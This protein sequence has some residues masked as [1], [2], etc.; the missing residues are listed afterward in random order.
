MPGGQH[1]WGSELVGKPVQMAFIISSRTLAD[2]DRLSA[3]IFNDGIKLGGNGI[4]GIIPGNPF[5]ALRRFSHRIKNSI[6]MIGQLGCRQSLTAQRT[7]TDRRFRISFYLDDFT[8]LYMGN[9][10]A[11]PMTLT[12]G[13][14]YFFYI[15][16]LL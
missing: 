11:P 12:A 16:H 10:T 1:I 2:D 7:A 4:Q 5:P 6:G 8:V 3:V 13:R 9:H 15:T 14:P